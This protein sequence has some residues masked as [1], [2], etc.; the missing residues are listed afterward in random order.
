MEIIFEILR[1]LV[2]PALQ[3]LVALV[4]AYLVTLWITLIIWT[5]RDIE[6]RSRSVIT[7]VFATLLVVFFFLPGALLYLILRPKETLD[8]AFQRALQEE[9]MLQDLEELPLCPTCRHYVH[10]DYLLCPQCHTRLRETCPACDHLVELRWSMC[11]YCATPLTTPDE[12]EILT[13]GETAAP[14]ALPEWVN[15]ALERLRSRVSSLGAESG[16]WLNGRVKPKELP[17]G[18]PPIK[19][20]TDVERPTQVER[21]AP[22]TEVAEPLSRGELRPRPRRGPML[23]PTT[24]GHATEHGDSRSTS[25]GPSADTMPTQKVGER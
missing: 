19:P 20:P 21:P 14:V 25:A 18:R 17:E 6:S 12:S 4:V 3:I 5:F 13:E 16:G 9:Y 11:P 8:E 22:A 1:V 7:Q 24:D 10:N 2:A 23:M 15:P